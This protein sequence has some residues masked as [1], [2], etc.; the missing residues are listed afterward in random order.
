MS[1]SGVCRVEIHIGLGPDESLTPL[2]MP[3]WVSIT[4]SSLAWGAERTDGVKTLG[5]LEPDTSPSSS[6]Y[7]ACHALSQCGACEDGARFLPHRHT[8]LRRASKPAESPGFCAP[9]LTILQNAIFILILDLLYV[10]NQ[11]SYIYIY[12]Y[13]YIFLIAYM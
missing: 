1:Q 6:P 9:Y 11:N 10:H 5:R 12:I 13:I 4:R 7:G 3:P 2:S 8:P